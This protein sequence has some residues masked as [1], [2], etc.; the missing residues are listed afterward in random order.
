[1]R[2]CFC[3]CFCLFLFLDSVA[4]LFFFRTHFSTVL[5]S[6]R[7]LEKGS[8]RRF[9][10]LSSDPFHL[11]STHLLSLSLFCSSSSLFCLF[12]INVGLQSKRYQIQSP[13]CHQGPL[14]LPSP[15][16]PSSSSYSSSSLFFQTGSLKILT[17][18]STSN[19]E[20]LSI[21]SF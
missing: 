10:S 14:L 3:F 2:V 21:F 20:G 13:C 1:M 6:S 8:L 5:L 16:F 12:I 11:M 18:Y 4:Y 9:S 19:P 7:K 17:K 15:S